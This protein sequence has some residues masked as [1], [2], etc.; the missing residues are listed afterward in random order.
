MASKTRPLGSYTDYHEL[1]FT[2]LAHDDLL[3]EEKKTKGKKR[4]KETNKKFPK[5]K[6]MS[7]LSETRKNIEL[8]LGYLT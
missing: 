3:L 5:E 7:S 8:I 6:C 1:V 4:K 2:H